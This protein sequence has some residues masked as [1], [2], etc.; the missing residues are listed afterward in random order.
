MT[1][2]EFLFLPPVPADARVNYGAGS[3]HFGELRGPAGRDLLLVIHGGFWRNTRDLSHMGRLCARLAEGGIATLNIEYR[4]IGD[5]GGGWPGTFD[6]IRAAAD[7]ARSKAERVAAIGFSA[8]GHL[9]LRLA[10]DCNWLAGAIGLAPVADLGRALELGLSNHVAA[11]FLGWHVDRAS[12]A[13]PIEHRPLA[14]VHL[15]H[16]TSDDIVPV[17]LSRNYLDRWPCSLREIEG[18]NHF[19]MVNPD[20]IAWPYVLEAVR[21]VFR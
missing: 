19:D 6:D 21:D 3:L 2:R 12:E 20:S 1:A 5:E 10:G 11:D 14:P 9:A 7:F 17:E 8:G 16:G 15:I 18:A 13:S 4:R